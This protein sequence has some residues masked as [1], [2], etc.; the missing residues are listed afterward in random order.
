MCLKAAASAVIYCEYIRYIS[1][2]SVSFE[3]TFLSL[4]PVVFTLRLCLVFYFLLP[5]ST[6]LYRC[7][8]LF[9]SSV[10]CD[11]FLLTFAVHFGIAVNIVNAASGALALN[12]PNAHTLSLTIFTQFVPMCGLLHILT[13]TLKFCFCI[14]SAFVYSS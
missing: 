12:L 13:M 3:V 2:I 11:T 10:F 5:L 1:L 14:R 6:L 8:S 9:L 4:F 7:L